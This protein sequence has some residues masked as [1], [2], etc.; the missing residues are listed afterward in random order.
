MADRVLF[1]GWGETIPGREERS[2][3]VF[4]DAVGIVGRMQ[5][6]GRIEE[7]DVVLF[8]PNGDLGGYIQIQGT[9]DQIAGVKED[10]DFRRN[11]ADAALIVGGLRHIEGVINEGVAEEMALYQEAIGKVPQAA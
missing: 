1:V 4:N 9:A 10:D 6:E 11:T 3:E 5:Q 8:A 2:L 7:F